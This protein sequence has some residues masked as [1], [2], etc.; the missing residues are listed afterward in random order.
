MSSLDRTNEN[1]EV[2]LDLDKKI[3]AESPIIN[4]QVRDLTNPQSANR[5]GCAPAVSRFLS[6]RPRRGLHP[7][8]LGPSAALRS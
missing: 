8:L 2:W 5:S 6:P 1:I 3:V 7:R 4:H